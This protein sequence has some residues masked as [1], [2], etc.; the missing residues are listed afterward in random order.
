MMDLVQLN[1][2]YT[3][4][5]AQYFAQLPKGQDQGGIIRIAMQHI[6]QPL[7]KCDGMDK[8]WL[9]HRQIYTKYTIHFHWMQYLIFS[10]D[11]NIT[12]QIHA[13]CHL[14]SSY[15]H[16]MCLY[17][18]QINAWLHHV[19]LGSSRWYSLNRCRGHV[20]CQHVIL[21][22][23]P[24]TIPLITCYLG[25]RRIKLGDNFYH[26]WV[27]LYTTKMLQPEWFWLSFSPNQ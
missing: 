7:H 26:P 25:P 23:Y 20:S 22:F 1:I 6:C 18:C 14:L 5:I 12:W 13:H 2:V 19:V 27:Y 3:H 17:H 8:F 15:S 9:N 24:T 11:I 10:T 21:P 16:H 4:S